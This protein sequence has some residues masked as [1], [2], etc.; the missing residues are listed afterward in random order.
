MVE[1]N[2]LRKT[3]DS[4]ASLSGVSL[5][6]LALPQSPAL[7]TRYRCEA[8]SCGKVK[9]PECHQPEL[10]HV[11]ILGQVLWCLICVTHAGPLFGQLFL[12][13][14]TSQCLMSR[15][16]GSLFCICNHVSGAG[17]SI[18]LASLGHTGGEE[19]AVWGHTLNPL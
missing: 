8:F 4:G 17:W 7:V 12:S 2:T 11:H 5:I 15:V 1:V 6:S 10:G 16:S 9:S 19:L 14:Y 13:S 3:G 18:L